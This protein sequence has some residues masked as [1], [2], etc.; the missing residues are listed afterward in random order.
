MSEPVRA[1]AYQTDGTVI[2]STDKHWSATLPQSTMNWTRPYRG[3][4]VVH[5]GHSMGSFQGGTCRAGSAPATTS[6]VIFP[7]LDPR[8]GKVLGVMELYKVPVQ[9][10]AA[11]RD[12][13]IAAV[14]GLCGL[15]GRSS[16][17]RCIGP[18]R[19]QTVSCVTSKTGLPKTRRCPQPL[20]WRVRSPTTCAIRWRPSGLG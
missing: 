18:W 14:A 9:L 5:N 4:L 15:R 2:W 16:L 11:I 13:L 6:R 10:N 7:I 8:A 20:N 19:V 1:N 17:S 3:K 12:A